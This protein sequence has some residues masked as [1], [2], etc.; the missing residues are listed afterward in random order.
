[1]LIRK[2]EKTTY[3]LKFKTSGNN[4]YIVMFAYTPMPNFANMLIKDVNTIEID[5]EK[6]N[7]YWEQNPIVNDT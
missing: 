1:M 7:S 5:L 2:I 6:L 4:F 3:N